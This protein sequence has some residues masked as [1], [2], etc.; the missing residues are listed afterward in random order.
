MAL[1]LDGDAGKLWVTA[2]SQ[3][4]GKAR[5]GR[6]WVSQKGNLFASLLLLDP[7]SRSDIGTLPFVASL[8]VQRAIA[9]STGCSPEEL[10]IKWPNDVLWQGRKISGI[11]LEAT[12]LGDGRQA[13]VIGCGINCSHFPDD[14]LYPVTSLKAAGFDITPE[15]LFNKL[16]QEMDFMLKIW[17]RGRGFAA[18]RQMWLE[19]AAGLGQ[20]IIARFDSH[21]Q[22][23]I[24][25]DVDSHGLL[26]L[27]TGD[28][29][30]L[31]SA[32]DIFFGKAAKTGKRVNEKN[33]N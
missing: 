7:S 31:I 26:V 4:A 9:I 21:Q 10:K 17:N 25:Q 27:K 33:T 20:P 18:I 14:T 12:V 8:A 29:H 23:G 13:V 22:E 2:E 11:L 24:F 16:Y 1:A 6:N 32:A 3:N 5:R 19:N 28:S 30:K 15:C